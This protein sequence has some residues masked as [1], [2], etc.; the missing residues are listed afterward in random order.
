[1][2]KTSHP[3]SH[4]SDQAKEQLY[5][6]A[7]HLE[8][9]WLQRK[10]DGFRED[11]FTSSQSTKTAY[12]YNGRTLA[13]H[14]QVA[15]STVSK[16]LEL[17]RKTSSTKTRPRSGRPSVFSRL[18]QQHSLQKNNQVGGCSIRTLESLLEADP[19]TGYLTRYK[20]NERKSPG[21]NTLGRLLRREE[22]VVQTLRYRPA[23]SE[24]NKQERLDWCE[25]RLIRSVRELSIHD[26]EAREAFA[27][28]L[29]TIVDVDECYIVY[30]VGT[31][32][33]Y[34]LP[35]DFEQRSKEGSEQMS[36]IMDEWKKNP[37]KILLFG[38][39]TAPHLLNPRTSHL[40]G[41]NFDETKRGIVQLRRIRAVSRYQRKT[42]YHQRHDLKFSDCTI[43]G[44]VYEYMMTGPNGL[45]A[46]L[47]RYYG[48]EALEEGDDESSRTTA[49]GI[50][51]ELTTE[52]S[53]LP[54]A[55]SASSTAVT[56][57]RRTTTVR[58]QQDNAGGHGFNNLQG[59][60]PTKTQLRMVETM[61]GRGYC[62][63]SQPRN[64]PEFN[65]LDLGFW[66]SIKSTVRQRTYEIQ[67]LPNPTHALIQQKMWE[68]VK[69]VIEEY[70]P[71]KL[72]SIAVQKQVLMEECIQLNAAQ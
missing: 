26:G 57:I 23:L 30:S 37:P 69:Q 43:N 36:V 6:D 16:I 10:L 3:R 62:V 63:Y 7:L 28:R 40:D 60:K 29:E 53:R 1:L 33:L 72:F 47:D 19:P 2:R 27:R 50:P 71:V 20:G 45:A 17:G 58:V 9:R 64:S 8:K 21:S 59:G 44:A 11:E 13:E 66:N 31:G 46:F 15:P 35:E 65:M 55:T 12:Q 14:Y 68:I 48:T 67:A 34:F 32:K 61:R 18:H 4:L 49:W 38:A 39:I 52:K 41:A 24:A 70:D 25:E 51:I 54:Q 5:L 56:T 22:L 42:K